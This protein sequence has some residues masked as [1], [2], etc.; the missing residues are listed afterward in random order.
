MLVDRRKIA[1]ITT[2]RAEYG[3]LYWLLKEVNEDSDLILQLI[4]GGAHL[5]PEFGMTVAQIEEDG[6]FINNRIEFLMS[7]D[8]GVGIGK[9]M[10]LATISFVDSFSRLQPDVVVLLG[11][12]WETLAIAMAA[13]SL[14]IPIAHIH[15]GEVTQGAI[16]DSIRHAIT[17]LSHIHFPASECYANRVLQLGESPEF[18]FNH[19]APGLDHLNRTAFSSRQEIQELLDIR[20]SDVNILCTYHPVTAQQNN[21]IEDFHIVLE[22]LEAFPEATVVFTEPNADEANHKIRDLIKKN[23]IRF[24]DKRHLFISLGLQKYLSLAKQV[25]FVLGNSS[26][27]LIEV[28]LMG[29]PTVNVGIRQQGRE[30]ANTVICCDAEKTKMLEAINKAMSKDFL[31]SIASINSPYG[32]G[33]AS[34]KIKNTLRDIN[35]TDILVK[36]FFDSESVHAK[37]ICY[38]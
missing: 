8:S 24:P 12:R 28:P 19:G 5:S 37:N 38:S 17:K 30:L 35:L 23:V 18:V 10:G 36:K 33:D 6:F 31:S 1:V 20:F 32:Y 7:S 9:A 14:K 26:S 16:D 15:G 34:S 21:S 3:L 2:T 29:T 22:A 11:D 25:N 13:T 4:V 27:G